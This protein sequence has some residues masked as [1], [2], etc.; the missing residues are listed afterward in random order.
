MK[1]L[2]DSMRIAFISLMVCVL[3]CLLIMTVSASIVSPEEYDYNVKCEDLG[4]G[5]YAF[6]IDAPP[7]EGTHIVDNIGSVTIEMINETHFDFTASGIVIHAAIV[8]GGEGSNVYNYSGPSYGST[9]T[10]DTDLGTRMNPSSGKYYDI[11]HIDFC[12]DTTPPLVPEFPTSVIPVL[13]IISII[14]CAG[15]MVLSLVRNH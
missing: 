12:Y 13:V 7:W 9:V 15:I 2:N 10:S 11:S 3:S 1:C 8:K 6:K 14:A 4:Y 5:A